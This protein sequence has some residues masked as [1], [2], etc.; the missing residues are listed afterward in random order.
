MNQRDTDVVV[1]TLT[2]RVQ[3]QDRTIAELLVELQLAQQA[4]ID[5]MLGQ[6]RLREAVL[7]YVGRDVD[8]LATQLTEKFGSEVARA[9]L[10]SLFV[11]DNA[12]VTTEV[13]EA[14]RKA[15]NRGMN[16][17][18]AAHTRCSVQLRQLPLKVTLPI[19]GLLQG[20]G[21]VTRAAAQLV[22]A[23]AHAAQLDGDVRRPLFVVK[24]ARVAA[25]VE[26]DLQAVLAHL[27]VLGGHRQ[28]LELP[29]QAFD[30]ELQGIQLAV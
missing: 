22:D 23:R 9:V 4:S 20:A 28:L 15:T 6:L 12:P 3:E 19:A 29:R 21:H 8:G 25:G 17:W 7:L 2:R 14:V 11:L 5:N 18:L 1:D 26:V 10:N 24:R 30:L 13:R 27:Q 16:R